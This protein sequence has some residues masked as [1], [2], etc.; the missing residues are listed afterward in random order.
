LCT[1]RAPLWYQATAMTLELTTADVPQEDDLRKVRLV[2]DAVGQGL[3]D[4]LS[5]AQ[6][7]GVSRRHVGYALN[8]A[9]VLGWVAEGAEQLEATEQ[10]KKLLKTAAGSAE[11]RAAFKS[12]I[13]GSAALR[14]VAP[15]LLAAAS[16]TRAQLGER[17]VEATGLSKSTADRR[18]QALLAWR[19]QV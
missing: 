5:I 1:F 3:Q 2:V 11:E 18:A 19:R 8:A 10:G 9:L 12:A 15:D 13:E 17:I 7:S 4:T 6:R 16:P 14:E